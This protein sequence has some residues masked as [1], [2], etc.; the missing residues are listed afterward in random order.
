MQSIPAHKWPSFALFAQW[1]EKPDKCGTIKDFRC[2]LTIT[3]TKGGDCSCRVIVLFETRAGSSDPQKCFRWKCVPFEAKLLWGKQR[4]GEE[5]RS[6]CCCS[7]P[8]TAP[9]VRTK[10]CKMTQKHFGPCVMLS[11]KASLYMF[12]VICTFVYTVN[13]SNKSFY[14]IIGYFLKKTNVYPKPDIN[15]FLTSRSKSIEIYQSYA[16]MK[17]PSA[18]AALAEEPQTP[19]AGH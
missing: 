5:V 8:R 2:R 10:G 6:L 15:L 1:L 16:E 14:H 7:A 9:R 11:I 13:N 19:A 4:S 3:F 12:S 17:V 18:A